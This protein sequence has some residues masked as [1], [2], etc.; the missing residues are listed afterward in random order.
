MKFVEVTPDNWEAFIAL[1]IAPQQ[2]PWLRENTAMHSLAKCYVFPQKYHPYGIELDGQLVGCFRFRNYGRGVNIVSFF[3]DHRFQGRGLGRA[4]RQHFI[5]W[6][7][8]H[9]PRAVEIELWVKPENAP[10]RKLYESLGFEYTGEV[11]AA[12]CLYMELQ[13]E[14]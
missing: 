4:A 3:I 12:G 7:Q 8:Q 10:A 13:L 2:Q 6:T 5:S 9:Y 1:D 11:D 14:K